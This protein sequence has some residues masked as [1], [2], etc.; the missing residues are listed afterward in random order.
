MK[1]GLKYI[2]FFSY[3][4]ILFCFQTVHTKLRKFN[5]NILCDHTHILST[6]ISKNFFTITSRGCHIVCFKIP[7]PTQIKS[8]GFYYICNDIYYIHCSL[9]LCFTEYDTK[10]EGI[11]L[12]E[13]VLCWVGFDIY[14]YSNMVTCN[15]AMKMCMIFYWLID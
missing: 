2:Y 15:T 6:Y 7:T 5:F 9:S 10:T 1:I 3:R 4:H 14:P 13:I 11:K 12:L 8:R